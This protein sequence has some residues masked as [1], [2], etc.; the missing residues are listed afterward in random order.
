[1][2]FRS[3]RTAE[4]LAEAQPDLD[5]VFFDLPGTINNADVVQTISKMDYIFTPIKMCIRDSNDICARSP[6]R[7]GLI[8]G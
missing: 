1:M 2:L 7:G 4:N 8:N 6:I 5:F 3:L